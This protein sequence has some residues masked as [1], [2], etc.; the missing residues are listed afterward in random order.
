M[1]NEK[2]AAVLNDLLHI[3]N[4]RIAGF[5][6]VEGKVW[7]SYSDMKGEYEHMIS[8]S[9]IMKNELINMISEKGG[10]PDDSAS[11]AGAIHRAWIDLKNSLPVGNKEQSTLE[12][13]IY[14]EKIAVSAY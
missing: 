4:D 11:A 2:I 6:R 3:T 8:E 10:K 12:N 5:E 14:G 9:K 13:V 7:E 1:N